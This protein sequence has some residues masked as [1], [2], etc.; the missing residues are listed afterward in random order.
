M[1]G[2]RFLGTYKA[3]NISGR[4]LCFDIE[5]S[6]GLLVEQYIEIGE[7]LTGLNR[8]ALNMLSPWVDMGLLIIDQEWEWVDSQKHNWI[9]EGF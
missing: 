8:H 1:E 7:T 3:K 5:I 2:R 9:K 6:S 4:V